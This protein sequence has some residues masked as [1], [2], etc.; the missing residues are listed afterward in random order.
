MVP[1]VSSRGRRAAISRPLRILT[2]TLILLL[3]AALRLYRLDVVPP[4]VTHDE[5]A[6]LQDARR[7]WEGAR[8]I[9]L[10]SAKGRE[11]FFDYVTAPL[12]G[13]AG[14]RVFTGRFSAVMWGLALV[15]LTYVLLRPV[16]GWAGATGAALLMA[17]AFWPLATSRQALRSITMP[18]LLTGAVWLFW[19]GTF[20][21]GPSDRRLGWFAAAGALL[22][23]G[24]YTYMPARAAWAVPLLLWLSLALTDRPRFRAR[25]RGVALMVA[26]TALIA[27]P[28]LIYLARHPELE[29]RVAELAGPLRAAMSGD[30]GPLFGRVRHTALMFSHRGDTHWMYNL[31]GRPLL[32]PPLAVLFYLGLTLAL[33]QLGRPGPRLLLVWLLVGIAPAL[34]TGVESSSLRAIA[35]QPA[36]FGLCALPLAELG[37]RT[38]PGWAL[39]VVWLALAGWVALD[40][41]PTYFVEWAQNRDVRVAYHTH[42]AAEADYLEHQ[43]PE[44]PVGLFAFY[45]DRPH[46]PYAMEVLLGERDPRLRWFDGQ[47][48][49]I[50]PPGGEMRLLVPSVLEFDPLL[51]AMVT[52]HAETLP[53]IDLY[54]TDFVTQVAVLAWDPAAALRAAQPGIGGP[55]SVFPGGMPGS[56]E[57]YQPISLPVAV[58]ERLRLIGYRLS[59]LGVAPGRPLAVITWWEVGGPDEALVLFSHVLN[60]VG[61]VVV[62]ADRLDAPAWNWHAGDVL[63]QVHRLTLPAD[64]APGTYHLQVGAYR[65]G[66]G[67]R[68]P[69]QVDGEVVDDRILLQPLEVV[70]P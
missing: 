24:F 58:G 54:A 1:S 39:I 52:P 20:G 67:T 34:V 22:G 35:A 44:E 37:R 6:H 42:L 47:G 49:L 15:A 70:A 63:A 12:V 66:D 43:A 18:V 5:A 21:G 38:R 23:L 8:P 11:P 61:E 60:D 9:Y 25:W 19:Q 17:V 29:V 27:A 41:A 55:V 50:F 51:A 26:V 53:P 16:L 36:V 10:E 14:M 57:E 13:L 30:W 31:S 2:L 68:L 64:V 46:D 69:V 56:A 45:P 4:G 59:T 7:I 48:A 3:A 62:Q 40:A 65:P 28:L 32:P 33:L